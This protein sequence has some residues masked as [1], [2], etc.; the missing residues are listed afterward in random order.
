MGAVTEEGVALVFERRMYKDMCDKLTAL[1]QKI[2]NLFPALEAV[3]PPKS[4]IQALCGLH[5]ALDKANSFLQQILHSS[6]LYLAITDDSVLVKFE[7]VKECLDQSL[8]RLQLNVPEA[9]AE[10]VAILVVELEDTT[11]QLSA[12]D[13]DAGNKIV[14]LLQKEKESP[15]YNAL[16]E[17]DMF[18]EVALQLGITSNKAV[19]GE[20]KALRC[21]LDKVRNEED[22]KKE[23]IVLYLLHLLRRYGKMHTFSTVEHGPL[24]EVSGSYPASPSERGSEASTSGRDS[25]FSS[26]LSCFEVHR[27]ES[28]C[29]GHAHIPPEEFRCPISLQLMSDPVIISSGQTY[30]RICIEKWFEE[31]HN[32][33]PKT[34][35]KLAHLG[36]TPNYCVKGL[37]TS[38][39]ERQSMPIP[40]PPSPPPS[41][42]ANWHWDLVS[43]FAPRKL[44]DTRLEVGEF[45]E[46]DCLCTDGE[47]SGKL[48][49]SGNCS[50]C[51]QPLAT[52]EY[53]GLTEGC[54]EHIVGRGIYDFQVVMEQLHSSSLDLQ[55]KAA[56]EIR[57]LTKDN[58]DAR[59]QL[60]HLGSI[61][62]LIAHLSAAIKA[63]YEN[64][65]TTACFALSNMAVNNKRYGRVGLLALKFSKSTNII[66]A[67]LVFVNTETEKIL[68]ML[69][70]FQCC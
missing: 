63:G 29:L 58:P 40:N 23:L 33:C 67:F 24:Q 3:Q 68:S 36:V 16:T 10:E 62:A 44:L 45:P 59:T 8:R 69:E 55:C 30:E 14:S 64:A 6:K 39:C 43:E 56:E 34:Q 25:D 12:S 48:D 20:K 60:S 38:W 66:E 2:T 5:W 17:L 37:I 51:S 26:E 7:R 50:L 35:Q 47:D 65:Q 11:C 18:N 53:F 4:G 49:V 27:K 31:G 21:L 46:N 13:Q 70:L 57:Y 15:G 19:L 42:I 32:T 1:V 61:P 52:N 54:V 22:K 28:S 41:P 9:L